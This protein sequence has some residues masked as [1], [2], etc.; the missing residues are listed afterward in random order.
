MLL[1]LESGELEKQVEEG[2]IE[3]SYLDLWNHISTRELADVRFYALAR[4]LKY[5]ITHLP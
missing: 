4:S 2:R 3:A 1:E 5:G